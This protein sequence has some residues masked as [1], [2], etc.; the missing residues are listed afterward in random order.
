MP[1]GPTGRLA[2]SPK[3]ATFVRWRRR[4]TRP[5]TSMPTIDLYSLLQNCRIDD[6]QHGCPLYCGLQSNYILR[7]YGSK[8]FRISNLRGRVGRIAG[9][10]RPAICNH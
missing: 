6:R 3:R 1:I 2:V 8:A 10:D 5:A 7:L 9:R 4:T